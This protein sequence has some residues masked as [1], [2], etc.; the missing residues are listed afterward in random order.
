MLLQT[1]LNVIGKYTL[2]QWVL[3]IVLQPVPRWNQPLEEKFND[4]GQLKK[5]KCLH[6]T[7]LLYRF[8][9]YFDLGMLSGAYKRFLLK[10]QVCLTKFEC[11][12]CLLKWHIVC[13]GLYYVVCFKKKKTVPSSGF[14]LALWCCAII[15]QCRCPFSKSLYLIKALL[16]EP[17]HCFQW[18]IPCVP[19][20]VL[21]VLL[22]AAQ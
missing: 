7:P 17:V 14:V 5:T 20:H 22:L 9:W 6:C 19:Y 2:G 21:S 16:S 15:Q 18:F 3:V 4:G 13:E 8:C 11:F 10:T 12:N 1:V